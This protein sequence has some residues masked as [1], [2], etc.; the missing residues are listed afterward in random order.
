M[1]E[2]QAGIKIAR[3][4]INNLRYAD[5]TT[6]V[7][8][9]KEELKSLLMKVKEESEKV[10]LKL[11]IQTTK[12]MA[13]CPITSWQIDEETMGVVRDFILGRLQNH[14]RWWLQP[15]NIKTLAPWKKSYDQPRRILKSR[16]IT[17]PKKICLVK[18]MVF[19]VV[20]YGCESW[21]ITKAECQKIDAFELWCWR[22]LLSVPWTARW[23][24]QPIIKEISPGCSLEGLMLKL[25]LQYSGHLMWRTDSFEKTLM[26]GKIEGRR[27]KGWQWMRWLDGITD[28]MDMNLSKHGSWWWTGRSGV[29]QSL[30]S[31]RVGHD[32]ATEMNWTE[33]LFSLFFSFKNKQTHAQSPLPSSFLSISLLYSSFWKNICTH[34]PYFLTSKATAGWLLSWYPAEIVYDYIT[35]DPW[36]WVGKVVWE[37]AMVSDK[38]GFSDLPLAGCVTLAMYLMSLNPSFFIDKMDCCEDQMKWCK[39]SVQWH[40]PRLV[41][42]FCGRHHDVPITAHISGCQIAVHIRISWYLSFD[43]YLHGIPFFHPL[44]FSLFVSLGLKWVPCRQYMY[45]SCFCIHSANLCLLFGA[46]NPLTF[47]VIIAMYF[48]I[49]IFLIVLG[50]YRPFFFH[51]T[52][53]LF[54]CGLMTIF[55]I[56]FGLLFLLCVYL[57]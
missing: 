14:C 34:F 31:Q 29:L 6:L 13:P 17:L 41:I 30:E 28:S 35:D 23:S 22:R 20:M 50:L 54:S 2:A 16:D 11:N 25:K 46:F 4:N 10:G 57:L 32:W 37:W 43:F 56:E 18:A 24:N 5:D 42:S 21:P 51:S 45:G 7:A 48:P 49:A 27:R 1:D 33:F 12:I 55:R 47:M 26:L 53:V 3:R 19:P 36:R 44:T 8:N 52:F 40:S 38:C 9:S 39:K 15:W